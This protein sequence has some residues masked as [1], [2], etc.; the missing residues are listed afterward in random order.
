MLAQIECSSQDPTD[1]QFPFQQYAL[2][3]SMSVNKSHVRPDFQLAVFAHGFYVALSHATSV[4]TMGFK[5]SDI[6][7]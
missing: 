3:H 5:V 2:H 1:A 6:Y 7:Y 4:H